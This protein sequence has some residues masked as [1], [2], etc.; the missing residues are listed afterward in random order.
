[1]S[2]LSNPRRQPYTQTWVKYPPGQN[3]SVKFGAPGFFGFSGVPKCSGVFRCS[4]V[5]VFLI[6][7]HARAEAL[8]RPFA[9]NDHMVQNPPCWRASSL[10]FPYWGIKTKASQAWW[11]CPPAWQILYHVIICCKKPIKSTIQVDET[12]KE[13]SSWTSNLENEILRKKE[14]LEHRIWNTQNMYIRTGL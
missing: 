1:M 3:N 2:I 13:W 10:L 4:G 7:I 6:L 11:A 8:N 9:T 12:L 5:P 14:T